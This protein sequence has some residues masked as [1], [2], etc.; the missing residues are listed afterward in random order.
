MNKAY[1]P[2]RDEEN[3]RKLDAY[4]KKRD[5]ET[6]AARKKFEEL[7]AFLGVTLDDETLKDIAARQYLQIS[8]L[9]KENEEFVE[10][11]NRF[12]RDHHY[13]TASHVPPYIKRNIARMSL[14]HEDG[15]PSMS[16][17]F[18]AGMEV[19][20]SLSG[21]RAAAKRLMNDPR[22]EEKTF[23]RECWRDWKKGITNYKSKAAFARDMIDKCEHLTSIKKVE[24]W[25]REWEKEYSLS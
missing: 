18:M 9:E 23:I 7:Y 19:Q 24:D 16:S 13:V 12:H 2:E 6:K 22:Q 11:L 14:E 3:K 5:A 21:S 4:K 1:T 17:A 10:K 25:C 15:G 8:A 20:R